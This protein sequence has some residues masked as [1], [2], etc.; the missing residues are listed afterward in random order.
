M[1][2]RTHQLLALPGFCHLEEQM[3]PERGFRLKQAKEA[4]LAHD[5]LG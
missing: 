5:A 1:I 3:L 2:E 4:S